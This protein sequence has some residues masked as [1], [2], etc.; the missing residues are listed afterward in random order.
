MKTVTN[1]EYQQ[2]FPW[3]EYTIALRDGSPPGSANRLAV[4]FGEKHIPLSF[5]I[6]GTEFTSRAASLETHFVSQAG[7]TLTLRCPHSQPYRGQL[8][9]LFGHCDGALSDVG[10]WVA[11]KDDGPFYPSPRYET[12][13]QA[14]RV[15]QDWLHKSALRGQQDQRDHDIVSAM[16]TGK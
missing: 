1:E 4:S 11:R 5:K 6:G 9:A 10:V 7:I 14:L 15:L 2:L 3:N 16:L 13:M 12:P 8:Q